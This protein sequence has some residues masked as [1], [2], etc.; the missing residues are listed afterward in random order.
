MRARNQP[1]LFGQKRSAHEIEPT[2]RFL[3]YAGNIRLMETSCSLS[4][5]S[6]LAR[7]LFFQLL[8]VATPTVFFHFYT[9]YVSGE[10]EKLKNTE[11]K[12]RALEEG[13]GQ[14]SLIVSLF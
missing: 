1:L 2:N 9:L 5:V 13:D 10:I 12:L 4:F 8:A 6:A 3:R 7:N 14:N 11:A